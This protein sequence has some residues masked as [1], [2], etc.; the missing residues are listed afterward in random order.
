MSVPAEEPVGGVK[1]AWW[2]HLNRGIMFGP[3]YGPKLDPNKSNTF[4]MANGRVQIFPL[5]ID[6][7]NALAMDFTPDMTFAD[8]QYESVL[9]TSQLNQGARCFKWEFNPAGLT[10]AITA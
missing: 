8:N 10:L 9:N 1:D 6:K 2:F 4:V 3:Q 5:V 7:N